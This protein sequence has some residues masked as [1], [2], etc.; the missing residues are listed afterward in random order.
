MVLGTEPL[1]T[2][3]QHLIPFLCC[4]LRFESGLTELLASLKPPMWAGQP[5]SNDPQVMLL[6][7]KAKEAPHPHDVIRVIR[8]GFQHQEKCSRRNFL[9]LPQHPAPL[10][11]PPPALM[12]TGLL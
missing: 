8:T 12:Q 9:P 11:S 7:L 10:S 6:T 2:V 3:S 5:G 1:A 4:C